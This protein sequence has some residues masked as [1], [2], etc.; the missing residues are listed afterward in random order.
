[1][2][3]TITLA[4]LPMILACQDSTEGTIEDNTINTDENQPSYTEESLYAQEPIRRDENN[5]MYSIRSFDVEGRDAPEYFAME[6]RTAQ[7]LDDLIAGIERHAQAKMDSEQLR[8]TY[9]ILWRMQGDGYVDEEGN[10]Y[11]SD[12][13]VR[14]HNES[15][16]AFRHLM[17]EVESETGL[18]RR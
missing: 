5:T 14:L 12:R 16:N 10:K 2:K 11:I 13:V 17:G 4:T 15:W 18:H 9:T 8:Q 6:P 7:E 3:K 1:M